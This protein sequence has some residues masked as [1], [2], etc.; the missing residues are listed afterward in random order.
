MTPPSYLRVPTVV[1]SLRFWDDGQVELA[2]I[3][4]AWALERLDG[5]VLVIGDRRFELEPEHLEALRDPSR[6]LQLYVHLQEDFV[7]LHRPE[8]VDRSPPVGR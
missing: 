8:D 4:H 6:G 7:W 5:D 3:D 2:P 1:P